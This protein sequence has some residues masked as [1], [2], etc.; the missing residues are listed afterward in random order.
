MNTDSELKAL[1]F[2]AANEM[3]DPAQRRAFLDGR[4]AGDLA[5]RA[6]IERLLRASERAEKYFSECSIGLVTDSADWSNSLSQ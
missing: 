6:T 1:L 5:L 2:E 3:A 4:C